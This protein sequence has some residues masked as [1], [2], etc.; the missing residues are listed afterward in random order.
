MPAKGISITVMKGNDGAVSGSRC[1][2]RNL[3]YF[4]LKK[5]ARKKKKNNNK[6]LLFNIGE[7]LA[8]SSRSNIDSK[9]N[10][11]LSI[12]NMLG[13]PYPKVSLPMKG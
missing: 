6:T 12:V 1:L 5:K 2:Q 13:N 8:E 10:R 7:M 11:M 4:Y 9:G 3:F